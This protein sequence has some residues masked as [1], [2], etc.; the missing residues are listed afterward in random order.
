MLIVW[1]TKR[2]EKK[3]GQVAEFC[4]ICRLIRPFRLI[5]VGLASHVYYV[6]FG[7]GKLAGHLLQCLECGVSLPTDPT[8]FSSVEKRTTLEL[9]E[10]IQQTHPRLRET[11]AARLDLEAQIRRTPGVLS[12]EERAAALL[13]PFRLLSPLV[14]ARWAR[15]SEMDKPAGLGCA[16]TLLGCVLLVVIVSALHKT[17]SD[18]D[19][20]IVALF[21]GL[22]TIYTFVQIHFAPARYLRQ[23]I[24]PPLARALDPLDPTQPE[25]ADCL[26]RCKT[27]GLKLGQKLKVEHLWAELERRAVAGVPV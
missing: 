4:P 23:K 14:E 2:I 9:E 6:S 13:E 19:T 3:L 22:G 5:R 8:I 26:T 17:M 20:G 1:G 11:C 21:F 16:G 10:L 7:S 15:S 12:P 18:S 27:A 24:V 25:L